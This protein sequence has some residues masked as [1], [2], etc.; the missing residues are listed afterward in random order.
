MIREY[1]D[2]VLTAEIVAALDLVYAPPEVPKDVPGSNVRRGPWRNRYGIA[3][4]VA[5]GLVLLLAYPAVTGIN[6]GSHRHPAKTEA[7]PAASGTATV[8]SLASLRPVTVDASGTPLIKSEV[9][10]HHRVTAWVASVR[11]SGKYVYDLG[12]AK[13]THFSAVLPPSDSGLTDPC[14][15]TVRLGGGPSRMYRTQQTASVPMAVEG[16]GPMTITVGPTQPT[17]GTANC[18]MTD[19]VVQAAAVGTAASSAPEPVASQVLGSPPASPSA[20]PTQQQAQ[21]QPTAPSAAPATSPASSPPASPSP[22]SSGSAAPTPTSSGSPSPGTAATPTAPAT[23]P[24]LEPPLQP[25]GG[26]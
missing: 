8:T 18:A 16:S 15:W 24:A 12:S 14:S 20:Q 21:P 11:R 13:F 6:T 2:E 19:P 1:T 10:D 25:A 4:T 3:A 26:N 9:L 17:S 7:A 23:D 5:A 22:S